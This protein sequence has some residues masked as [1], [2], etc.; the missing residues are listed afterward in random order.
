MDFILVIIKLLFDRC[1]SWGATSENRSNGYFA[2]KWSLWSK[3]SARRGRS[4]P[5]IFPR[6][7]RPMNALQLCRDSFHTA[8]MAE[9]LQAKIDR[10][11]ATLLQHGHDDPKF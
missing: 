4:P 8:V 3:I 11:S 1:Y 9:A 2:P 7:V 10:K 6:I 5:I